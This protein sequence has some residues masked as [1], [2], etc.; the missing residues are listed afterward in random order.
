M[1]IIPTLDEEGYFCSNLLEFSPESESILVNW[2]HKNT[3][4]QI[5]NEK[6]QNYVSA[7][8]KLEIYIWRLALI[9]EL[10]EWS[11][12]EVETIPTQININA[13]NNAIKLIE[14]FRIQLHSYFSLISDV[15]KIDNIKD[16]KKRELHEMLPDDFTTAEA[17][18]LGAKCNLKVSSIKRFIGDD[19]YFNYLGTAKY[20]KKY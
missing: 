14:Y 11:F 7:Y 19:Y 3:D 16:P 18:I 13:A 17:L 4:L 12:S 9:L 20:S 6:Q 5:K 10:I 2:Q 8:A 15:A 1:D